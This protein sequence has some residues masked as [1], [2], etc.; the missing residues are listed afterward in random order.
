MCSVGFKFDDCI[1]QGM[2]SMFYS[3]QMPEITESVL[4]CIGLLKS[5][6]SLIIRMYEINKFY[7]TEHI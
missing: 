1:D 6:A 7:P 4:M 5:K 3:C 2:S